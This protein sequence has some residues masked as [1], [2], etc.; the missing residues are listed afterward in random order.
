MLSRV[1]ESIYWMS[2]QVERAENLARFLEITHEF[3]L[4]QP[5]NMVNSWDALLRITGD[6][7]LFKERYD[8]A[9]AD[10]VSRFLAFDED[11]PNSMLSSLRLAR[12]N[13]RSVRESLSSE[14]F[15]QVNEFYHLVNHAAA[16]PALSSP[17]NFLN[18]VRLLAIQWTGVLDSTMPQ[19]DGWH[20]FNVGRMTERADKTSRIL[21]V[22]YFNLLPNVTDVGTAVDDLQW[23]SLLKAIS[24]IEAYR[25]KYRV[26]H[27]PNVVRFFLFDETFPRSVIYCAKSAFWSIRRIHESA[28][29]PPGEAYERAE[30]LCRRLS[31]TSAEEVI[32]G[33]MHEAIDRLQTELNQLGDAI[34]RDFFHHELV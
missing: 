17:T 7:A 5:Q 16:Q 18:E 33:N 4:D 29:L 20:F 12:Q 27:I 26:L 23:A 8:E 15:E 6:E 21:D 24:G 2:R 11:Y 10:S 34:F 30:Q 1:A 13:A 25:R 22:K 32:A 3:T 14:V 19:D 28:D 9:N 31:L